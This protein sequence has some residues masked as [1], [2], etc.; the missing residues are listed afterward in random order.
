MLGHRL[1]TIKRLI[2]HCQTPPWLMFFTGSPQNYCMGKII[3]TLLSILK[4]KLTI[5]YIKNKLS[6]SIGIMYKCRN[7]FDKETMRNLYFSFIYPY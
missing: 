7:Y 3:I 1:A 2:S 6:K 5:Q 4:K